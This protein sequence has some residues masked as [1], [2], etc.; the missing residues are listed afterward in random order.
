MADCYRSEDQKVEAFSAPL[1]LLKLA[2]LKS[3]EKHMTRSGYYRYCL[4]KDLG[5]S[6]DE[7]ITISRDIRMQKANNALRKQRLSAPGQRPATSI[8]TRITL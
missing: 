4:A 3:A 6:E 7:A 1:S 5:Y 8:P 2:Q